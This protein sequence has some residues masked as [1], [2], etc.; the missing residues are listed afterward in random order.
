MLFD[1]FMYFT[2]KV[3]QN[4][5]DG[6]AHSQMDELVELKVVVYLL[7]IYCLLNTNASTYPCTLLDGYPKVYIDAKDDDQNR[8]RNYHA[9]RYDPEWFLILG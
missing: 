2:R 1:Q 8:S 5:V 9:V 4:Y 6:Q 7:W 3:E